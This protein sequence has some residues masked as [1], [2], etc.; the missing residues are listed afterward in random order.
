MTPNHSFKLKEDGPNHE[1]IELGPIAMC[2][3]EKEGWILESLGPTS[4]HWKRLAKE[5][6]VKVARDGENPI[7]GKREA[8][9]PLQ[10]LDPNISDLK[11]RR[12][13]KGNN[14]SQNGEEQKDGGLA[15]ATVIAWNC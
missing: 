1:N 15:V 10:E 12:G 14:Q 5:V 8:P 11:C 6:H 13:N 4:R 2:F 3:D 7:N 9:I